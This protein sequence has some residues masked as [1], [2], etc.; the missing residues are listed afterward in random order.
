MLSAGVA[1]GMVLLVPDIGGAKVLMSNGVWGPLL[2]AETSV[3][4]VSKMAFG[5]T[6]CLCNYVERYHFIDKSLIFNIQTCSLEI[7]SHRHET[8]LECCQRDPGIKTDL[9]LEGWIDS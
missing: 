8:A 2:A 6:S 1:R 3:F 4:S 7:R 5:R 9:T